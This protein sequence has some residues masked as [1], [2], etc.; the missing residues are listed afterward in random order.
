[1]SDDREPEKPSPSETTTSRGWSLLFDK[2]KFLK[3]H[4][5]AVAAVGA[6]LSGLVGYW[7]TYRTVHEVMAPAAVGYARSGAQS[8]PAMSV[9][10]TPLAAPKGDAEAARFADAL[11][12]ELVSWL[13]RA[14][15]GAG[16]LRVVA[17]QGDPAGGVMD[18]G[19]L[20]RR[21]N[22]RYVLE[23]N[24]LRGADGNAVNLQLVDAATG[25]QVWSKQATVQ[26]ADV[27]AESSIKLGG[28]AKG[29]RT[30]L[31][32]AETRR[33]LAQPVSSLSAPE[34]V[35]RVLAQTGQ[36]RTLASVREAR[37]LVDH[38]L[39]LD[40]NWIPALMVRCDLDDDEIGLD[41][42]ADRS[43]LVREIDE[44]S[45]RAVSLDANSSEALWWRAIAL[46][47]L[48]RWDA[49]LEANATAIKLDPDAGLL[50]QRA[51]IMNAI[52]RP[53]EALTFTDR[54]VAMDE[55]IRKYAEW[56]A[57]KSHLLLGQAE[58]AMAMCE[59]A[60]AFGGWWLTQTF[61]VAAYANHG[62]MAKAAAAKAEMLRA[63]PG[64]TVAQARAYDEPL[65]PEY[66][67]L[68]EKYYY[69]GLRKAGIPEN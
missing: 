33:V 67:K 59:K 46:L 39:E 63:I 8:P 1:M 66:A 22:A 43:R 55:R 6:V 31:V 11:T 56:T 50:A 24:V 28:L 2:L 58:Q 13:G 65:H 48:E 42:K 69:E 16:R 38:A 60:A 52:G 36:G 19:E 15:G 47:R 37:K 18:R 62:D 68:A 20:G 51:Y 27:S 26:D 41:P 45:A 49:A 10:V 4:I 23:G 3:R 12:R 5:V 44:D 21:L 64:Y 40:P 32:D 54:A 34:L 14:G 57:C 17:F 9:V 53:A 25:G 35:L 29:V 61:L 7:T 30:A